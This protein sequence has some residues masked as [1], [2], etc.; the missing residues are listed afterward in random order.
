MEEYIKRLEE[1]KARAAEIKAL[2]EITGELQEEL[3]AMKDERTSLEGKIETASLLEDL[4]RDI[5]EIVKPVAAA[6]EEAAE[7]EEPAKEEAVEVEEEKEEV[8]VEAPEAIAASLG[9]KEAHVESQ[10]FSGLAI[11]ASSAEIGVNGK[12]DVTGWQKVL[13]HAKGQS[14]GK[15]SFASIDRTH[16]MKRV[17]SRNSSIDNSI[18]M[19]QAGVGEHN[20]PITAAACH[21]GPF[22]TKK[23]INSLG[24]DERPV[25]SLFRAVDAIG[26]FKYVRDIDLG[27]VSAG[28]NLWDCADQAAVVSG[29]PATWKPCVDLTCQ[30]DHQVDPYAVFAC[31][32]Y[33]TFQEISHPELI[34]DFIKKLGIQYARLAEQALLDTL[35]AD[36]TTLTYGVSGMGVL[37]ELTAILGHLATFAGYVRRMDWSNYALILPKGMMNVL[38]ADEHR[39]G[40]SRGANAAD[41]M[42]QIREL[43]VGQIVEAR[44]AA[45]TAEPDILAAHALYHAPGTTVPFNPCTAIGTFTAHLVPINAYVRGESSLVEAGYQRD[46]DLIRQNM[47]QFF[48]EGQEFLEKTVVDI[49][50]WTIELTSAAT[51]GTSAMVT[52]EAC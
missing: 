19:A 5:P 35:V 48:V 14:E 21:C 7:V 34:D 18:I 8:K 44:D 29:T 9:S 6:E 11:I 13:R 22:E 38:V 2:D 46:A 43:G 32:R 24:M 20:V 10:S 41:I 30:A 40:F 28:V 52:P 4:G 16:N 50:S 23:E 51:G 31:G 47:V 33:S 37:N 12:L 27:D 49:P 36:S 3:R 15:Y 45:T 25:A 26:P 42:A 1:I 17:T 39:R